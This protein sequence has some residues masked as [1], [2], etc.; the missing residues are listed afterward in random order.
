M[1][2]FFFSL[3][4]LQEHDVE[5]VSDHEV[6]RLFNLITDHSADC[7]DLERFVDFAL[8]EWKAKLSGWTGNWAQPNKQK[9]YRANQLLSGHVTEMFDRYDRSGDGQINGEELTSLV[10]DIFGGADGKLDD[11]E[12]KTMYSIIDMDNS[13]TIGNQIKFLEIEI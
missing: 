4:F 5:D 1:V 9:S 8:A 13:G 12:L 3:S 2:T 10:A 6:C 7:I 11:E